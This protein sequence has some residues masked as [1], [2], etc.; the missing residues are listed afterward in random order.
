MPA[1]H[2]SAEVLPQG[3]NLVRSDNTSPAMLG[4]ALDVSSVDTRT[5]HDVAPWY[6]RLWRRSELGTRTKLA[7]GAFLFAA[8]LAF[9]LAVRGDGST[10][11][12]LTWAVLASMWAFFGCTLLATFLWRRQT[13]FPR[14]R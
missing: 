3:T 1:H 5:M 2:R 12:R 11:T 4:L 9:G 14:E 6:A 10:A 8:V 13:P 7:I